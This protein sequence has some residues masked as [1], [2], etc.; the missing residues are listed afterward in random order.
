[1]ANRDYYE[2]L[3]VPRTASPD[4]I[5]SAYRKLARQH[6]PD[7]NKE[8]PKAAE[9]KFKELSEAYEVLASPEKRQRYDQFG[10]AAVENDFGPQGFT[11]QNF[12]HA[13][14]LEDLLGS[15]ALFQQ[16]FG[17]AFGGDLFGVR[18]GGNGLAQCVVRTSKSPSDSR[19]PRLSE[20]RL[21]PWR[22]R[23]PDL[24]PIA[25]AREPKMGR[26]LKRAANVTARV[27][28]VVRPVVVTR[29]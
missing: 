12:T 9:E 5:K 6:H 14:D 20:G 3:G 16:L 23:T 10:S 27:K 8:N 18:G 7:M 15:S 1:M 13:G 25:T 22:Y 21:R 29:S 24:A 26:R 19:C 28:S 2:V 17:G 4:E 11:W